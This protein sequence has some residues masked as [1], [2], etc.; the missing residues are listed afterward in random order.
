MRRNGMSWQH[1]VEP[2]F[3]VLHP[4]IVHLGHS[5]PSTE[6]PFVPSPSFLW[7]TF[8]AVEP[9]Q[10]RTGVFQLAGPI[11]HAVPG[12]HT[13]LEVEDLTVAHLTGHDIPH[14]MTISKA[15]TKREVVIAHPATDFEVV[16]HH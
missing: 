2:T 6:L 3:E 15:L 8:K 10:H 5:T 1:F 12:K 7:Q 11:A 14:R 13:E 9:V 4:G 16:H